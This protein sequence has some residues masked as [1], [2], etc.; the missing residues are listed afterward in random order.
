ME[1]DWNLLR[2]AMKAAIDSCEALE[3]AGYAEEH[4]ERSVVINGQQVSIQ[5]FLT[6]AWALPESVRYAV[7]RQRHDAGADAPYIPEAARILV[8]VAA[9]CAE[10]I[11]AGKNPLGPMDCEQWPI[12]TEII[13]IPTLGWPSTSKRGRLAKAIF[14]RCP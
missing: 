14:L 13:S 1:T 8:A 11:G 10:I 5:E 9:A 12:G 6:S 4:R 2:E 7:I 3:V